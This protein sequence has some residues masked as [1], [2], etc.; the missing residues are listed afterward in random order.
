MLLD[1]VD[2]LD[3]LW[4]RERERER[5]C[6]CVHACKWGLKTESYNLIYQHKAS[7]NVPISFH[8][9][10]TVTK[11]IREADHHVPGWWHIGCWQAGMSFDYKDLLH[12]IHSYKNSV[13]SSFIN[14]PH[15]TIKQRMSTAS[16]EGLSTET[17]RKKTEES[18]FAWFTARQKAE[19]KLQPHPLFLWNTWT[20]RM[21]KENAQKG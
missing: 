10:A 17:R 8:Q 15:A 19:T 4:E 2:V 21:Q 11:E 6:V 12:W 18:F 20:S 3:K 9:L 16:S 5:L 1:V 13:S 7:T 14:P